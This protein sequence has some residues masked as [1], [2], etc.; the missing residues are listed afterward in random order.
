MNLSTIEADLY[1]SLGY[2]LPTPDQ[3]VI[4]RLRRYINTSQREILSMRGLDRL[5]RAVLTCASVANSPFMVLPQSATRVV[6]VSDRVNNMILE[7]LSLQ[8]I[9]YNDPGLTSSVSYPVSYAVWHLSAPAARDPSAAA[10]L[11]VKSDSAS[12]GAIPKTAFV[13]G[14]RTG[15]GYYS[16]SV[17]LNGTTAVQVG[18]GVSDWVT[19]TKFYLTLP[20]NGAATTAIGN[21]TLTQ[22]S[23]VG[24]ELS[25]ITPGTGVA[26]YTRLHLFPTPTGANTYYAD[27]IMH[28]EDMTQKGDEP[29][30]PED[31]HW[32][33]SCG[34]MKK[35]YQKREKPV[36]YS[37][38][39]ERWKQG[40]SDLKAFV[41]QTTGVAASGRGPRR[42]SQLGPYYPVGS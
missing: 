12:D 8:D 29:Y 13:E 28:I 6:A 1:A 34:A 35:E 21:V 27:V 38:E 17:A 14:T 15:G 41:R 25:R 11:F 3:D 22:T 30:L 20:T 33:L 24:T 32:L 36:Q 42:F 39:K 4:D 31:F 10:A 40:I 2:K 23:G 5:R 26:R 37:I 7:E 19:I 16:T 9:R 18:S